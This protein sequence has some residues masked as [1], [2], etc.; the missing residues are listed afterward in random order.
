MKWLTS[1][2]RFH[3]QLKA[4]HSSSS[5][6]AGAF[7][8]T[9]VCK[10]PERAITLL[11]CTEA[12][13]SLSDVSWYAFMESKETTWQ[14]NKITAGLGGR[15]LF[16]LVRKRVCKTSSSY[17]YCGWGLLAWISNLVY[18]MKTPSKYVQFIYQG[19]VNKSGER[20][21]S[22]GEEKGKWAKAE[23]FF[24]YFFF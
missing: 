2:S 16:F 18:G 9:T 6:Q 4:A 10:S 13:D 5:H 8:S 3:S 15:T 19:L 23:A 1:S 12:D 20:R 24:I 21:K 11:N 7:P 14:I 22:N 17:S